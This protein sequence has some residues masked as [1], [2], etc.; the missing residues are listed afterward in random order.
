MIIRDRAKVLKAHVDHQAAVVLADFEAKMAK[1][2]SFSDDVIW[3]KAAEEA[4]AAVKAAEE[5]V[6]QRCEE[7]GIPRSLS[8]HIDVYWRGRGADAIKERQAELRRAA[9]AKIDEMSKKAVLKIE[10]QS[11][12]LRTQVVAMGLLSD[13]ARLF[14]ESLATVDEA[15]QMLDFKAIEQPVIE[16]QSKRDES[17]RRWNL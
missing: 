9:K 14:L 15:M 8:P 4:L 11:L 16:D 13:E 2:Y 6:A 3:K 17:R 7:M 12:D 10:R 5:I 1:E